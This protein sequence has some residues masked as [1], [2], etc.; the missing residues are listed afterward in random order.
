MAVEAE[1]GSKEDEKRRLRWWRCWKNRER[2]ISRND[3][4]MERTMKTK[5]ERERERAFN[6]RI[7]RNMRNARAM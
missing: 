4:S 5:K 2:I 6:A 1:E 3:A 7:R